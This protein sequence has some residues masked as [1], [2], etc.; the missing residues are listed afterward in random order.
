M[1]Q[2][3]LVRKWYSLEGKRINASFLSPLRDWVGIP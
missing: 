3:V 1:G 2:L